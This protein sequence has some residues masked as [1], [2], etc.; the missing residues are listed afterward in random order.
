MKETR[1]VISARHH[2]SNSMR[3]ATLVLELL[4]PTDPTIMSDELIIV[5]DEFKGMFV[6][7]LDTHVII[8][9]IDSVV[10]RRVLVLRLA[11]LLKG[12]SFRVL[13]RYVSATS[14]GRVNIFAEDKY[15][16]T[17]KRQIEWAQENPDDASLELKEVGALIFL[18]EGA[19]DAHMEQ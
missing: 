7:V 1:T 19:A 4:G 18:R 12:H 5:A 13:R 15:N 10:Y 2:R 11:Q 6:D 8:T 16:D 14:P 17:I 9:Y 3:S